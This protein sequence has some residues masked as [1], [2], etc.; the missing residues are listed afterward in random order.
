MH[1]YDATLP[2]TNTYQASGQASSGSH[3]HSSQFDT[4]TLFSGLSGRQGYDPTTVAP[5]TISSAVMEE[6]SGYPA[7]YSQFS[8]NNVIRISPYQPPLTLEQAE[9]S[10][11]GSKRKSRKDT[12][13]AAPKAS[14]PAPASAAPAHE[15]SDQ[16]HAKKKKKMTD[17]EKRQRKALLAQDSRARYAGYLQKMEDVLPEAYKTHD[18]PPTRETVLRATKY[19]KDMPA[20]HERNVKLSRELEQRTSELYVAQKELRL[21]HNEVNSSRLLIARQEGEIV[22]LRNRVDHLESI[23]AGRC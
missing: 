16:E 20:I 23:G 22:G 5:S 19:I 18:D 14:Q 1:P 9:S 2:Y 17:E 8:E 15:D 21:M 4:S 11:S 6:A 3:V 13:N 12:T 10:K 7:T